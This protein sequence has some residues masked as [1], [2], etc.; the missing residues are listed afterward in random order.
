MKSRNVSLDGLPVPLSSDETKVP[1]DPA[2][3]PVPPRTAPRVVAGAEVLAAD[4]HGERAAR[5]V[6][7][8]H[9]L[10]TGVVER[11]S[12]RRG[13]RARCVEL[14]HG[15]ARAVDQAGVNVI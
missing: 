6:R 7:S 9:A 5:Q 15:F 11:T 13:D 2:Q 8:S 10:G 12:G 14:P 1:V 4:R 3:S